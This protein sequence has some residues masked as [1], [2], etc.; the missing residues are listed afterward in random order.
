MDY[1]EQYTRVLKSLR[2]EK[3]YSLSAVGDVLNTTP[4]EY[5]AIERGGHCMFADDAIILGKF[6]DV[7]LNY[8]CGISNV[9]KPFPKEDENYNDKK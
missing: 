3:G 8:L 7:S 6:Y 1:K 9:R 5:E 2:L 4:E